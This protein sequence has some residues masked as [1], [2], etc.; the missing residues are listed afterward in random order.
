MCDNQAEGNP[1]QQELSQPDQDT[2][3]GWSYT[4]ELVIKVQMIQSKIT[5]G[6]PHK[7][8]PGVILLNP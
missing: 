8:S 7:I 2:A 3:K 5:L 1:S 6:E 4:A